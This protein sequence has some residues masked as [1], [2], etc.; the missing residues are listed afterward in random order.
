MRIPLRRNYNDENAP[1]IQEDTAQ[2]ELVH[3]EEASR[4]DDQV[5]NS[6]S[7]SRLHRLSHRLRLSL[8][9]HIKITTLF[10]K[11]QHDGHDTEKNGATD[12]KKMR[13]R[14]NKGTAMVNFVV[15]N[16][17]EIPPMTNGRDSSEQYIQQQHHQSLTTRFKNTLKRTFSS[18]KHYKSSSSD[19]KSSLLLSSA[20]SVI[21]S[22]STKHT[23]T[24][25]K[26]KNDS[27][28]VIVEDVHS[29]RR[30]V[31]QNHVLLKDIE[32]NFTR[33]V[34]NATTVTTDQLMNHSVIQLIAQ[35]VRTNSTP[36][37]RADNDQEAHLA[38]A[39][40]GGGMRGAVSAGMAAAIASLGLTDAFDSVYGSSAGCIV[41]A[42][43]VSRQMYV[44]S[45]CII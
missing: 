4:P 26:K 12:V 36:G 14:K 7:G 39:I 5:R 1:E 34:V 13:I 32:F 41:G 35:R 15:V 33:P 18:R 28:A 25:S 10:F 30:Q 21:A 17:H 2:E 22:S 23:K 27:P 20:A 11:S 29:L 40:E 3:F 38:L 19:G 6:H 24:K 37:N 8:P 44:F 9:K 31:L 45:E 42:Y 16:G 43:M